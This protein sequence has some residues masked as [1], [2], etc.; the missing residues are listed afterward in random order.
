MPSK[1]R[2]P[3]LA[4]G[5]AW[6]VGHGSPGTVSSLRISLAVYSALR[7]DVGATRAEAV[8]ALSRFLACE[9]SRRPTRGTLLAT[10]SASATWEQQQQHLTLRRDRG[11]G[12]HFGG[13]SA[14]HALSPIHQ[15][16]FVDAALLPG[17]PPVSASSLVRSSCVEYVMEQVEDGY[18][19]LG[20]QTQWQPVAAA[21]RADALRGTTL[22]AELT[23]QG[24]RAI[25]V[26]ATTNPARLGEDHEHTFSLTMARR[27]RTNYGVPISGALVGWLD[28]EEKKIAL[29]GIGFGVLILRGGLHVVAVADGT[30]HE[31]ARGEGPDQ[32]VI[33][34]DPWRD[35]VDVYARDIYGGSDGVNKAL[36]MWGSGIVVLPPGTVMEG[37]E[38]F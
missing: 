38:W 29:D 28:H 24:W 22:A 5:L 19:Q 36:C 34:A 26:I 12:S 11:V 37:V 20:L 17:S 8:A 13:A 25:L 10:M 7:P 30:V 32:Q 23:R 15:Q 3:G 2:G 21:T 31:L 4:P 27:T 1:P 35:I 33:Y 14:F 6:S 16:A 18:H 9:G